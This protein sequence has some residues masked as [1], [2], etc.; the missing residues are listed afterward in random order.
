[1]RRVPVWLPL[2]LAGVA[3]LAGCA[4]PNPTFVFDAGTAARDGGTAGAD[5]SIAETGAPDGVD[6]DAGADDAGDTR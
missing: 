3:P 1:M 4:D 2:F 5:G 6:T